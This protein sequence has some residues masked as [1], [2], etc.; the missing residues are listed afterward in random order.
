[1]HKILIMIFTNISYFFYFFLC[2][3]GPHP[4]GWEPIF[5]N[6]S[7]PQNELQLT[8]S[9]LEEDLPIV[10]LIHTWCYLYVWNLPIFRFQC[11]ACKGWLPFIIWHLFTSSPSAPHLPM[12]GCYPPKLALDLP[13]LESHKVAIYGRPSSPLMALHWLHNPLQCRVAIVNIRGDRKSVV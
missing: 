8:I 13:S 7:R 1:M 4:I 10:W 9:Q 6:P 12:G 3:I 5:P 2:N 11:V